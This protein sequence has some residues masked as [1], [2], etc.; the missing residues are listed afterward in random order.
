MWRCLQQGPVQTKVPLQ[1]SEM[2][3]P[4]SGNPQIIPHS[5]YQSLPLTGCR[6]GLKDLHCHI[7]GPHD[8]YSHKDWSTSI[9]RLSSFDA[10][11]CQWLPATFPTKRH[12]NIRQ[13]YFIKILCVYYSHCRTQNSLNPETETAG[14]L[15]VP[16]FWPVCCR[17]SG[18]CHQHLGGKTKN[19]SQVKVGCHMI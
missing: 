15:M 6:Q 7:L 10:K 2:N 12:W 18:R 8:L 5:Q 3:L 17:Q 13:G 19:A 16:Q 9:R 4:F 14:S 11:H 1:Y